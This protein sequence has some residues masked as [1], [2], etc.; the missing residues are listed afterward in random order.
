M[1][2]W[3]W[4]ITVDIFSG[5]PKRTS[6]THD[7]SRSTELYAFL[8]VDEAHV[9]EDFPHSSEF[10]QSERDEQHVDCRTYWAKTALLFWKYPLGLAVVA[11]AGRDHFQQYFA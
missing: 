7:S 1:P 9:Q 11:E 4:R 8:E 3:N 5:T 10:L 6:T 2:S